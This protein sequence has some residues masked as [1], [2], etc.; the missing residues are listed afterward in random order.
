MGHCVSS[1]T[2]LFFWGMRKH[3]QK[4]SR[5]SFTHEF[6]RDYLSVIHEPVSNGMCSLVND[7]RG[8]DLPNWSLRFEFGPTMKSRIVVLCDKL[9]FATQL[10]WLSSHRMAM[11][12]PKAACGRG[13]TNVWSLASWVG[14]LKWGKRQSPLV[15]GT[16]LPLVSEMHDCDWYS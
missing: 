2:N 10:G 8:N 1:W 15:P 12:T 5:F 4:V 14:R 6:L 9:E 3:V 13:F 11:I 7:F 16:D